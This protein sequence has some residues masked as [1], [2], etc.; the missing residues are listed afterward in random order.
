MHGHATPA[1]LDLQN[2][3]LMECEYCSDHFCIQC[4]KMTSTTYNYHIKTPSIWL[5]ITCLP[6]MREVIKIEKDIEEKC[7]AHYEK[8]QERC[9]AIEERCDELESVIDEKC[10]KVEMDKKCS[11]EEV[12]KLIEGKMSNIQLQPKEATASKELVSQAVKERMAEKDRD[13][14]DRQSRERNIIIFNMPEPLTNLIDQRKQDDRE[15]VDN[16]IGNLGLE[17]AEP[18]TVEK[19]TRLGFRKLKPDKNPR[20]VIVCFSTVETKKQVLKNAAKLKN[21][22]DEVIK[23]CRVSND[24]TKKDREAEKALV[25]QK[26]SKNEE[27]TGKWKYVIRGPPGERQEKYKW[28][29]LSN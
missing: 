24:M 7:N 20:P 22:E 4:L 10:S 3:K 19:V 9:I 11:K 28:N 8:F 5:C 26:F 15:Q 1:R 6:K 12:E 27:E 2:D 21:S 16:I 17:T 13:I 14:A 18:V 25:Q 29:L 23:R